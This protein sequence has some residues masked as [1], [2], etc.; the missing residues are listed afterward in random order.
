MNNAA[1][2]V[3]VYFFNAFYTLIYIYRSF[4][5]VSLQH[6]LKS[7]ETMKM[8]WWKHFSIQNAKEC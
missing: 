7:L 8:I 1:I 4:S 2:V 6:H 3:Y 5:T